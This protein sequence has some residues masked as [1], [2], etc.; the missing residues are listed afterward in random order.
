MVPDLPA[1][2]RRLSPDSA[3]VE[4]WRRAYE[5]VK[6]RIERIP[7]E[8]TPHINLEIPS[9]VSQV[10][11]SVK[12]MR[13]L[14]PAIEAELPRF[15]L[16]E[17]DQLELYA[18]ALGHVH[19]RWTSIA[20]PPEVMPELI[21]RG[22]TVRHILLSQVTLLAKLG[23]LESTVL[24]DLRGSSAHRNM[25]L[26]L[27]GLAGALREGWPRL[28]GKLSVTLQD[29]EEADTLAH[30]IFG[31]LSAREQALS[32]QGQLNRERQRAYKLLVETYSQARRAVAYL[33]WNEG[34]ADRF[35]P[36]LFAGRGGAR[37]K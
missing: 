17:F 15:D 9:A 1:K 26:D 23:L 32:E 12:L 37:R 29:I 3:E 34:D 10:L 14:R 2:Y 30:N 25:A 31:V 35:A 19:M 22:S 8:N 11:G 16:G 28:N 27:A 7:E 18:Y 6:E 4:A 24:K 5:Q 36:S 13:S 33:R 20:T 21:Q